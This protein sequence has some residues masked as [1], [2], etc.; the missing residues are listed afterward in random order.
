MVT[1][2]KSRAET[3]IWELLHAMNIDM[4][5]HPDIQN[6]PARVIK[7][8]EEVWQGEKYTNREIADMF[9]KTFPATSN[10]IVVVKDIHAFSYCEHHLALMYNMHIHVGYIPEGKVIGLSKISRIVDMCC[11]RLQL[12]ERITKDIMEVMNYVVGNNVIVYVEA[13]HS[14]VTARGIKKDSA[15]TVTIEKSGLFNNPLHLNQFM[16]MIK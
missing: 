2:D 12:Q 10:G 8:L 11:K 14:C 5:K 1:I 13:E 6:T 9:G 15:K 16:G 7:M 4:N 3:A